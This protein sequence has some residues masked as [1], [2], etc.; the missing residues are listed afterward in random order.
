MFSAN[1]FCQSRSTAPRSIDDGIHTFRLDG[2]ELR[3]VSL[4]ER[5]SFD[6]PVI[7]VVELRGRGFAVEVSQDTE[8]VAVNRVRGDGSLRRTDAVEIGAPSPGFVAA[9]TAGQSGFVFWDGRDTHQG[10]EWARFDRSGEI[11]SRH[12]MSSDLEAWLGAAVTEMVEVEAGGR[13]FVLT[14]AVPGLVPGGG[15]AVLELDSEGGLSVARRE[16]ADFAADDRWCAD[17]MTAFEVDG[18]DCVATLTTAGARG[19][20][21]VAVFAVTGDGGLFKVEDTGR[22]GT[23]P[24]S[25]DVEAVEVAGR[26]FLVTADDGMRA[27]R[28]EPEDAERDG[29]DRLVGRG[30]DDLLSGGS[31]QDHLRGGCGGDTLFGAGGRDRLS[32]GGGDDHLHGGGGKDELSGGSGRD[33]A[34]GGAG[35][36][37]IKGGAD[38][39]RLEG[40]GDRLHG[41]GGDDRILDGRGRDKM[42][43]GEGADLFVM[44]KDGETDA[45]AGWGE[46]D[47]IDLTDFGADLDFADLRIR[48]RGSERV[49]VR[50][51]GETFRLLS[52]D[53]IDADDL[54]YS[55]LVLA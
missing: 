30:G 4:A 11:V 14:N 55:D 1:Q 10:L 8:T 27:C 46:G 50:A 25:K 32:G 16:V 2:S 43:G 53:R 33:L 34:M 48:Q 28:F 40:G 21:G 5:E 41:Q 22:D 17:K 44:E 37:R 20:G 29:D 52:D 3:R 9:A 13:T 39:D 38:A 18:Q 12:E 47:R 31:G 26:Q 49:D 15:I 42:W 23:Y 51:E 24:N 35:G 45:I 54:G 19:G 36:D 7:D 6:E